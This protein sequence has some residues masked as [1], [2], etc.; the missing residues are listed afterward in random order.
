[1]IYCKTSWR[2]TIREIKTM[3]NGTRFLVSLALC[4]FLVIT[5]A[6]ISESGKDVVRGLSIVALET[7]NAIINEEKIS[8]G[9]YSFDV[10]S[11]G[12]LHV[13]WT[14]EDP[15]NSER[16]TLSYIRWDGE[17]WVCFDGSVFDSSDKSTENPVIVSNPNGFAAFPML[18]LDSDDNPHLTW[19]DIDF[20]SIE[21]LGLRF[22]I[23]Y[24]KAQDEKW[25]C[26]DESIFD[27]EDT[28]VENPAYISDRK[29]ISALSQL[30]LD[31]D[32]N[33]HFTWMITE[34]DDAMEMYSI[35]IIWDGEN[36]ICADGSIYDG[37]EIDQ[38]N[39][40]VAFTT[41]DFMGILPITVRFKLDSNNFPHFCWSTMDME[42]FS[43]CISYL[44]WN[45]DDWVYADGDSFD[46]TVGTKYISS[47]SGFCLFPSMDL[48]KND[49]PH[50]VWTEMTNILD[51]E[52]ISIV[53]VYISWNDEDW[54]CVDG[55]SFDPDKKDNPAI[56]FDDT[57]SMLPYIQIDNDNNPHISWIGTVSTDSDYSDIYYIKRDDDKWICADGSE[58]DET[59]STK[60]SSSNVTKSVRITLETTFVLDEDNNPH[61]VWVEGDLE[62]RS[63]MVFSVDGHLN[64]INWNGES[65]VTAS[66]HEYEPIVW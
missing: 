22:E 57:L 11:E 41:V 19:T 47:T 39:P 30:I 66:G 3:K 52:N 34:S 13:V 2:T 59:D 46:K 63:D 26:L 36:W 65:W 37:S 45:G 50:I 56:I 42:M 62:D 21:A 58:F 44:H 17:N 28:S 49:N 27:R 6:I 29:H 53:S 1:M 33:P 23:I 60:W 4:V 43:M 51:L 15:E 16:A 32:N 18:A 12:F 24:I 9:K 35:Y 31:E 14:C 38:D 55:S 5:P 10:D 54:V 40:A 61:Y 7:G 8:G 48:D 64:Y 20:D 25:I